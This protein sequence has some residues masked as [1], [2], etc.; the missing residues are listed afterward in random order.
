MNVE[1][2]CWKLDPPAHLIEVDIIL[3]FM[4][5]SFKNKEKFFKQDC[6]LRFMM[7]MDNTPDDYPMFMVIFDL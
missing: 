4:I 6:L 2:H 7:F 1:A 5:N 3:A